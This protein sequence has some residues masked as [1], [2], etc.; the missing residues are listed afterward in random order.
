[1]GEAA[2]GMQLVR[3]GLLLE[4]GVFQA[5]VVIPEGQTPREGRLGS[6]MTV[7]WLPGT[8]DTGTKIKSREKLLKPSQMTL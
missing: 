6:V 5:E 8:L 1:M 4:G 7:G 3:R 2:V